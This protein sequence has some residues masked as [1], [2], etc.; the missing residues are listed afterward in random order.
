MYTISSGMKGGRFTRFIYTILRHHISDQINH[1]LFYQIL[2]N[3]ASM[4]KF[5]ISARN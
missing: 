1:R 3:S 5:R 2:Q 4:G